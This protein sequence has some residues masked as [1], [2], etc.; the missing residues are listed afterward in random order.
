MS[1]FG[2]NFATALPRGNKYVTAMPGGNVSMATALPGGNRYTTGMT[3][4][5]YAT[6]LPKVVG[7]A[8]MEIEFQPPSGAAMVTAPHIK[9]NGCVFP[10]GAT[11]TQGSPRLPRRSDGA[12]V[13]QTSHILHITK[14]IYNTLWGQGLTFHPYTRGDSPVHF[15]SLWPDRRTT[16]IDTYQGAELEKHPYELCKLLLATNSYTTLDVLLEEKVSE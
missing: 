9:T 14:T 8:N 3:R 12:T 6:A 11:R 7:V 2:G 1:E 4:N 10:P 13:P 15:S 16:L 5:N